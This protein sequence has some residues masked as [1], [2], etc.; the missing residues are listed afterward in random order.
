MEATEKRQLETTLVKMG[1]AGLEE[2]GAATPELIQQI[3]GVVNNWQPSP[4]RHGEWIDRHKFLRD[5]FSECDQ[6]DRGAM[7]SA[8]VPYLRFTAYSLS[9]YET[10][11]TERMGALASKGAAKTQGQAPRP[12]LVGDRTAIAKADS[13]RLRRKQSR[14]RQ[15][16]KAGDIFVAE[17]LPEDAT[18]VMATLRCY[19]C[20]KSANFLGDTPAGAMIAGRK[21]GWVRDMGVMKEMC[22]TCAKMPANCTKVLVN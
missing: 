17:G 18:H 15:Q 12:L 13:K 11:M 5:L 8:I 22:P 4:N 1:L 16:L 3:A 9:R 10:M 7:Y 19:K 21:A 20:Q 6:A 2:S 14:A